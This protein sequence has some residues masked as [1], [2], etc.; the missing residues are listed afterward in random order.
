MVSRRFCGGASEETE[1]TG[2]PLTTQQ[3]FAEGEDEG[4]TIQTSQ[5]EDQILSYL[6]NMV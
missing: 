5:R 3:C 2:L 6:R 1:I 4:G